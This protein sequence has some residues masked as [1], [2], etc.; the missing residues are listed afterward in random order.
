MD[1]DFCQLF[2]RVTVAKIH[3]QLQLLINLTSFDFHG[4]YTLV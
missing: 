3:I 2:L 4:Y 1:I